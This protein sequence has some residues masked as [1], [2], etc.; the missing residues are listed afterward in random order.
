MDALQTCQ[1]AKLQFIPVLYS[2][3]SD[4]MLEYSNA[5]LKVV[6]AEPR[7]KSGR[8]VAHH[9]EKSH[10]R[11]PPLPKSIVWVRRYSPDANSRNYYDFDAR[12][13]DMI[14]EV[15]KIFLYRWLSRHCAGCK[16]ILSATMAPA[17]SS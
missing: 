3:H 1:S 2:E 12:S 16:L 7:R 8:S 10:R 15:E 14:S 11:P 17:D 4:T 9:S 5:E 6:F 13:R